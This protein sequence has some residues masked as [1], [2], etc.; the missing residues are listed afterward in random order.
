MA[1]ELSRRATSAVADLK[2]RAFQAARVVKRERYI[3]SEFVAAARVM[4]EYLISLDPP[5]DCPGVKMMPFPHL[6]IGEPSHCARCGLLE[7]DYRPNF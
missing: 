5:L 3:G 6:F 1:K 4:A 2:E 7:A